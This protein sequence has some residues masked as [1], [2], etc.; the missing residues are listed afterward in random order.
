[1]DPHLKEILSM[2]GW[3]ISGVIGWGIF[4]CV[5]Y[6]YQA[7]KRRKNKKRTQLHKEVS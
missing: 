2:A 5:Y 7:I 4:E 1:M 3:V 6:I